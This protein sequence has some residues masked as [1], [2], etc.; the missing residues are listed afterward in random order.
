MGAALAVI[1]LGGVFIVSLF[2]MGSEPGAG[3]LVL[4]FIIIGIVLAAGAWDQKDAPS[5]GILSK[6]YHEELSKIKI[7]YLEQKVDWEHDP[8][9][10]G[11]NWFVH[12]SL[13]QQQKA[14][15]D[16]LNK[17]FNVYQ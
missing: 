1:F 10:R 13:G 14:E 2:S 4:V 16:E 6:K 9:N 5:Q 17:R 12:S 8:E 3:G 15:Q 7:R 11:K